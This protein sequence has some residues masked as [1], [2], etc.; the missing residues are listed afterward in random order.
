MDK[1]SF[2]INL[3]Y[4]THGLSCGRECDAMDNVNAFMNGYGREQQRPSNRMEPDGPD[5][6][7]NNNVNKNINVNKGLTNVIVRVLVEDFDF[8]PDDVKKLAD[9][10]E[11]RFL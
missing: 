2:D 1:A 4:G 7:I 5:R 6:D 10:V 3:C 11:K 8:T 9:G